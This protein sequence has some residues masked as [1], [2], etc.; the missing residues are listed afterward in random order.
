M[1]RLE[2]KHIETISIVGEKREMKSVRPVLTF[3]QTGM[4]LSL[5]CHLVPVTVGCVSEARRFGQQ[6]WKQV[7]WLMKRP[8]SAQP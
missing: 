2:R 1:R 5:L 6:K 4:S 3:C 7:E 8:L